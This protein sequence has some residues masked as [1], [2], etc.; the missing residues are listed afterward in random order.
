[1]TPN[2]DTPGDGKP[3]FSAIMKK[4]NND[5]SSQLKLYIGQIYALRSNV[6]FDGPH[7]WNG[8]DGEH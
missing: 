8:P 1:M 2:T 3:S 7:V 4:K 5:A 6:E